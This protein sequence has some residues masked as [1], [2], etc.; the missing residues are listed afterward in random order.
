MWLRSLILPLKSVTQRFLKKFTCIEPTITNVTQYLFETNAFAIRGLR[1]DTL[2]QMLSLAN[3]RPGW[4][5]IVVED[6]GGLVVAAVIER[7]GGEN[8]F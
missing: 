1:P 5:G 4:K 3:V 6:V 7:L 2:C 8:L